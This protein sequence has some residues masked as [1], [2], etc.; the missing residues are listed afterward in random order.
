MARVNINTSG[1]E[2]T[3]GLKSLLKKFKANEN[4]IAKNT[5]IREREC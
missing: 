5:P 4:E 3:Y 1:S 2:G